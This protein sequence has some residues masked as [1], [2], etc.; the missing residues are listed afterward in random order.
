MI[1]FKEKALPPLDWK[2]YRGSDYK[3]ETTFY[4]Y[5][6]KIQENVNCFNLYLNEEYLDFDFKTLEDAKEYVQ[7]WANIVFAYYPCIVKISDEK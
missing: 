6:I 4:G 7:G 1:N 2:E 3:F 5:D